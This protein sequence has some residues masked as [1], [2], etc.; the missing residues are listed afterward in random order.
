M[1]NITALGIGLVVFGLFV[2]VLD[3]A[4][5]NSTVEHDRWNDED[6]QPFDIPDC[7]HYNYD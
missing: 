5:P 1:N 2:E 7:D 4:D 3:S 6:N